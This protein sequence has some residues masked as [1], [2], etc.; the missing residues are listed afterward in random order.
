[1]ITKSHDV[2]SKAYIMIAENSILTDRYY[3]ILHEFMQEQVIADIKDRRYSQ[4]RTKI[5]D[6]SQLLKSKGSK[7]GYIVILVSF[8]SGVNIMNNFSFTLGFI[9]ILIGLIYG[10]TVI[11]DSFHSIHDS[12]IIRT[13]SLTKEDIEYYNNGNINILKGSNWTELKFVSEMVNKIHRIKDRYFRKR[14]QGTLLLLLSEDIDYVK[15]CYEYTP[16]HKSTFDL[17]RTATKDANYLWNRYQGSKNVD[18]FKVSRA[19]ISEQEKVKELTDNIKIQ[20]KLREVEKADERRVWEAN[21]IKKRNQSYFVKP[22]RINDD[23]PLNKT[24]KNNAKSKTIKKLSNISDHN[25]GLESESN[26]VFKSN[27]IG[28]EEIEFNTD[29]FKSGLIKFN[30]YAP[31]E[32]GHVNIDHTTNKFIGDQGEK[33]VLQ[34]ELNRLNQD[35]KVIHVSKEYGDGYGFDVFSESNGTLRHIEVKSTKSNNWQA[36]NFTGNELKALE[37]YKTSYYVYICYDYT[38]SRVPNFKFHII[39]YEGL[40]NDFSWTPSSFKV[41]LK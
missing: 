4:L 18:F 3:G 2:A 11:M 35:G 9:L 12:K 5:I 31:R 19:Y 30:A 38:P 7:W 25:K 8:L 21:Y 1:M 22:T 26:K 13:K 23:L 40:K 33:A 20:E 24:K 27:G 16:K 29:V 32:V 36:F 39:S 41:K 6:K 37:M 28:I 10:V 14:L 15:R 34:Y 17:L